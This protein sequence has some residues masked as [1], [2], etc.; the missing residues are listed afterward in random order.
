MKRKQHFELENIVFVPFS[1]LKGCLLTKQKCKSG[2]TLLLFLI[3]RENDS[4]S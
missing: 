4:W 1:D 2:S 3:Y